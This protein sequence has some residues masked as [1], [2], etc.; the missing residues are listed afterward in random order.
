[1]RVMEERVTLVDRM[2]R[3]ARETGRPAVAKLYE[4]RGQEY[5]RYAATLRDA[6]ILSLRHGRSPEEDL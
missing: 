2:T 1:M 4:T 3:D 5:R 6:A